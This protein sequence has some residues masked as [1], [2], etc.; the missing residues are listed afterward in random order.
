MEQWCTC[1]HRPGSACNPAAT[2]WLP[3]E[4]WKRAAQCPDSHCSSTGRGKA[5]EVAEGQAEGLTESHAHHRK[6]ENKETRCPSRLENFNMP[7]T[8]ADP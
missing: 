3:Q 5:E 2:R 7:I 6:Q 1:L 8:T 4:A